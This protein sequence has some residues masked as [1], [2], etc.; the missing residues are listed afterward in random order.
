MDQNS[1]RP[2]LGRSRCYSFTWNNPSEDSYSFLSK[3]GRDSEGISE[4]IY[5]L[6]KGEMRRTPHLQGCIIFNSPR[7]FSAVRKLLIGCHI[8]KARK[9]L[10]LKNYCKKNESRIGSIFHFKNGKSITNSD[11][12]LLK[13]NYDK[14]ILKKDELYNWQS[15]MYSLFLSQPDDRT[16]IWI[17]D[18]I[19]KNGKSA[20]CR[21]LL[22]EHE[23]HVF[24]TSGNPADIKM[25][26][27]EKVLR[28][29]I[30]AVR[31]VL[32]DISRSSK[33]FSS[34]TAEDIKNGYFY[35]SKYES[36]GVKLLP[37][38]IFIFSNKYPD[39]SIFSED[40]WKIGIL[41]NKVINWE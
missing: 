30:G 31:V 21:F 20:F 18:K 2:E 4:L 23:D 24:S 8:E 26:L 7:Y 17:Y 29:G 35:S 40:R 15:Q 1:V 6:E 34:M 38:H 37:P 14:L 5:Q 3:L 13:D 10:A 28:G 9:V 16:I 41:E 25:G 11:L 19:G 12:R 36:E 33:S 39:K 32:W 22:S 27:K